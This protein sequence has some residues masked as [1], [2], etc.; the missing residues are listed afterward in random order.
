MVKNY[1]IR[2]VEQQ[3]EAANEAP[4]QVSSDQ[5]SKVV[6]TWAGGGRRENH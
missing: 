3:E 4:S 1:A 2:P 6:A 5:K